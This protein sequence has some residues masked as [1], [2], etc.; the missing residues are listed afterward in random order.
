MNVTD[1]DL[2]SFYD[3]RQ[4]RPTVLL[5]FTRIQSKNNCTIFLDDSQVYFWRNDMKDR[6]GSS[7]LFI[8]EEIWRTI[9]HE[10]SVNILEHSGSVGFISYRVIEPRNKRGGIKWWCKNTFK[11]TLDS[12]WKSL[13]D[14]FLEICICDAGLGF[15]KTLKESYEA[16][17]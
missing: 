4:E 3:S 12:L 16:R 8:S 6:Y 17:L 1:A 11:G 5:G 15:F 13:I 7:P 10:L 2:R 14:G 9:C